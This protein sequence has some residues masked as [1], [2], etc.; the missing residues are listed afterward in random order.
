MYVHSTLGPFLLICE[1]EG[2]KS[3]HLTYF[4]ILTYPYFICC[5][6]N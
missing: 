4:I 6:Q 1:A 3:A 5:P 2:D